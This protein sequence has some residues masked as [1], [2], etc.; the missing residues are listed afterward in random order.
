MSTKYKIYY[1]K[2]NRFWALDKMLNG[3]WSTSILVG[4]NPKQEISDT[5]KTKDIT[6]DT[7]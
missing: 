2:N 5:M 6:F 4:D 7:K 3:F 1:L